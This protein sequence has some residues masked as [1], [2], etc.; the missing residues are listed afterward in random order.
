MFETTN[1]TNYWNGKYNNSDVAEGT[2]YWIAQY[3]LGCSPNQIKKD[4]G[5]LTLIRN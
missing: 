5:Y 1:P 4:K 3:S 2:Y